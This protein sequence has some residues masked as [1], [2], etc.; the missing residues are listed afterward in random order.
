MIKLSHIGIV[1]ENIEEYLKNAVCSV[2]KTTVFDSIQRSR[3]ALVEIGSGQPD[4]ELIEPVDDEATTFN[5]LEKTGGGL[6]HLCYDVDSEEELNEL[7]KQRGIK[8][9]FG[10]AEAVLFGG[11]KIMFGYTRNREIVEFIIIDS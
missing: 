5:F 2:V 6:H 1:V 3:I 8:R 10:P 11:K 4:I 9:I 7:L